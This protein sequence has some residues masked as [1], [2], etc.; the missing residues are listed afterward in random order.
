MAAEDIT[1]LGERRVP[2]AKDKHTASTKRCDEPR[3][4][5][6][7]CQQQ[8]CPDADESPDRRRQSIRHVRSV[9]DS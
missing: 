8:Q 3:G 1:W 6:H 9:A 2:C 4:P 7:V 5:R